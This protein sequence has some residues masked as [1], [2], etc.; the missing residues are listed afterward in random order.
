MNLVIAAR[1]DHDLLQGTDECRRKGPQLLAMMQR[2]L[3]QNALS[4]GRQFHMHFAAVFDAADSLNETSLCQPVYELDGTVVLE[5]KALGQ[6]CDGWCSPIAGSLHGEH[7]LM[8][9]RLKSGLAGRFL[10][11]AQETA[12][13]VT[14]LRQGLVVGGFEIVDAG[15]KLENAIISSDIVS[16]QMSPTASALPGEWLASK[17]ARQKQAAP[18]YLP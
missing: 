10:A 13:L 3:L 5:L 6:I 8:M 2:Q 7:K 11:E 4:P 1:R 15:H 9:L 18:I 16:K 12:D 17:T 14:E